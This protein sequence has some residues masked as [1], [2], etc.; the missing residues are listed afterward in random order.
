MTVLDFYPGGRTG[1]VGWGTSELFT[2][3]VDFMSMS[4]PHLS[5]DTMQA[6]TGIH[7][8]F[9]IEAFSSPYT[10]FIIYQS[11]SGLTIENLQMLYMR[12][13]VLTNVEQTTSFMPV[14]CL[15]S[16]TLF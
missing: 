2:G 3:S 7:S 1:V 6:I 9:V 14:S 4:K 10:P 13:K 11:L 5:G 8:V 12:T 15:S 16:Q